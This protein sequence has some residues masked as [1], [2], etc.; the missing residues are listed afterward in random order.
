MPTFESA[1]VADRTYQRNRSIQPLQLPSVDGGNGT[2][3][4]SVSQLPVGL[5]SSSY[6]I[7]SG[8]PSAAG[9]TTVMYTAEDIDNETATLPLAK[10]AGEHIVKVVFPILY[11]YVAVYQDVLANRDA[12]QCKVKSN[13]FSHPRPVCIDQF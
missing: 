3:S 1:T 11:V 4:N 2:L 5:D 6:R 8:M 10:R 12:D 13:F 9:T 7:I